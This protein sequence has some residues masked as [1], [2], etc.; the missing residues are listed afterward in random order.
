[1]REVNNIHKDEVQM[2]H[3]GQE[4]GTSDKEDLRNNMK[5]ILKLS[6]ILELIKG[7][8]LNC[9]WRGELRSLSR[10]YQKERNAEST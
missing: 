8:E 6:I 10:K 3:K 7:V 5:R 9:L 4:L 1:M 2:S